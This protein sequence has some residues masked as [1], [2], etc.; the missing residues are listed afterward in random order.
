VA[1]CV[2]LCRI[3]EGYSLFAL[4]DVGTMKSAKQEGVVV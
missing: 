1:D 3:P 2:L 4:C